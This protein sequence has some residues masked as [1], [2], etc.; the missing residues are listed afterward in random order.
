MEKQKGLG[1]LLY[2]AIGAVF[3]VMGIWMYHVVETGR[4][5][6]EKLLAQE[7]SQIAAEYQVTDAKRS[8]LSDMN[9]YTLV[10]VYLLDATQD[11]SK[12]AVVIS[13]QYAWRE[14]QLVHLVKNGQRDESRTTV[15]LLDVGGKMA[16]LVGYHVEPLPNPEKTPPRR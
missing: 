3:V 5:S 11:G 2:V 7:A 10:G 4:R 1:W 16:P 8:I 13:A 12:R 15:W 6:G 14:G 9:G